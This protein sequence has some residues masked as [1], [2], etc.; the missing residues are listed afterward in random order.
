LGVARGEVR[1]AVEIHDGLRGAGD[2]VVLDDLPTSP[3]AR[4]DEL[5]RR[6][7]VARWPRYRRGWRSYVDDVAPHS[8]ATVVVDNNDLARPQLIDT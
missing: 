5:D 3:T 2:A 7:D 4:A 1:R 8:R 6:L